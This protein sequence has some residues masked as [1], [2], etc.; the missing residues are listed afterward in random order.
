M[1]A[2]SLCLI[3]LPLYA[4]SASAQEKPAVEESITVT[5]TGV[6]RTGLFAIGGETTGTTVTAKKIAFELSFGKSADLRKAAQRLDGKQV[7]VQGSLERRAGVEVK[8]R[9]IITVTRL[10]EAGKGGTDKAEK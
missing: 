1:K 9:W 6:L 4:A 5:I 8:E 2:V 7:V 3:A 10:E